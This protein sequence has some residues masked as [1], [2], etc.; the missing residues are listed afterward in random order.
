M[1]D[2]MEGFDDLEMSAVG[3]GRTGTERIMTKEEEEL[4]KVLKEY[5]DGLK[6]KKKNI[7]F[8]LIFLFFI[9]ILKMVVFL[10]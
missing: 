4:E 6:K 2:L 8:Y 5:E 1:K 9:F 3:E 10:I 7:V